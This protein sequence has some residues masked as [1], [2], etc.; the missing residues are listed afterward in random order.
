MN[1]ST[2]YCTGDSHIM[3]FSGKNK[4]IKMGK[5]LNTWTDCDYTTDHFEFKMYGYD[6]YIAYNV[7]N[8]SI[9][10]D[11]IR[12][13]T[14]IGSNLLFSFG[15]IDCRLYLPKY[16]N[17]KETV[18]R[19]FE[20]LKLFESDYK[21]IV[22]M[23]PP[24][25]TSIDSGFDDHPKKLDLTYNRN[26]ITREFI[27]ACNDRCRESKY[28]SITLFDKLI[29]DDNKSTRRDFWDAWHL[30]NKNLPILTNEIETNLKDLHE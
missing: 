25:T 6:S 26:K 22:Y 9:Y 20:F 16:E 10:I 5:T 14:P 13:M 15:E 3:I 24:S 2:I 29:K 27:A 30:S 21:I 12:K 17:V 4:I 18:D 28:Y 8:K 23:P 11:K 19:Y 7:K 1:K